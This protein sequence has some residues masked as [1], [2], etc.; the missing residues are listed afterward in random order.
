MIIKYND[1]TD[2]FVAGDRLIRRWLRPYVGKRA[3][4]LSGVR[5]VVRNFLIGLQRVGVDYTYNPGPFTRIGTKKVI[6]FG[7]GEQGLVGVQSDTPLI[8]AVGFPYPGEFPDLCDRYNVRRI[9]H[10]SQWIVDFVKMAGLYDEKIFD[11]WPAGINTDYWRPAPSLD[12]SYDVLIYQKVQWNKASRE[13][14]LVQPI[15]NALMVRGLKV[16]RID[17]GSYTPMEFHEA[18][19][20]ARA[21]VFLS[22]HESQGLAY[23][24]CLSCNV[25][26]LAWNPGKWLDPAR[27]M[28]GLAHVPAT[29]VPYFDERCGEVFSSF[30]EFVGVFE[31]FWERVC[32]AVYSPRE[33]V[34]ENLSIEKSTLR[35]LEIYDAI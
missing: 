34:E 9:L 16:K 19:M 32:S 35:M 27:E 15:E 1:E 14:D 10:H 2:R 7:L 8:C 21:M 17:Y 11:L 5:R 25:P 20:G 4:H 31:L 24:E 22:P 12:K 28:Y 13:I 33:Y 6:S 23:Q 29:S 3:S 30:N 26:V 18:L